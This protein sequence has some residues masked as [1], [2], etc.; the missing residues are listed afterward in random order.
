MESV[1]TRVHVVRLFMDSN[2]KVCIKKPKTSIPTYRAFTIREKLEYKRT[3]SP[4][5]GPDPLI[6][7]LVGFRLADF[8]AVLGARLESWRLTIT[9]FKT[10][11]RTQEILFLDHP[12]FID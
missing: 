4:M 2:A 12:L 5:H 10:I 9:D 8:H 11:E 6:I 7:S 1:A 3:I